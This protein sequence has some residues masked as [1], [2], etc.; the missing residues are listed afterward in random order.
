MIE[1]AVT[2]WGFRG[3]KVH[4]HDAM[5][6]R[7]VCEAA[8]AF[9]LP[10]LVDVIGQAHTVELLATQYPD[11]KVIVPHLGSF[12]DDWRAH[13]TVI[14]LIARYPNV[15]TDTSG[16]RRFDYLVRAVERAGAHKV[17]VRLGRPMAPSRRRAAQDPP[18]PSGAPG[19]GPRP[20]EPPRA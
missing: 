6:T 20:G 17:P 19:G 11:L 3:I 5:A 2:A 18:T 10:L 7:E 8:R 14:D 13:N 4:G 9:R 16:V 15:Y 1:R 12:A